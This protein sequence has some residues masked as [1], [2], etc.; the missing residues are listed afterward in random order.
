MDHRGY[1]GKAVQASNNSSNNNLILFYIVKLY[2]CL[3][4]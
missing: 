1:S 3:W 4:Q 2:V